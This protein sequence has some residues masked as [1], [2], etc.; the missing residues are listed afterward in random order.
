MSDDRRPPSLQTSYWVGKAKR[1]HIL[2]K[3]IIVC[4]VIALLILGVAIFA[5]RP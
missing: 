2:V 3:F 1:Q 5:S 4:A